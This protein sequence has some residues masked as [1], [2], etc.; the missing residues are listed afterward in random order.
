MIQNHIFFKSWSPSRFIVLLKVPI[1][2]FLSYPSSNLCSNWV[3]TERLT[4]WEISLDTELKKS[5][6]TSLV[7]VII[8]TIGGVYEQLLWSVCVFGAVLYTHPTKVWVGYWVVCSIFD[9]IYYRFHWMLV[10]SWWWFMAIVGR[11]DKNKSV[12][13]LNVFKMKR[14]VVQIYSNDEDPLNQICEIQ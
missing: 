13:W 7:G 3:I 5:I 6:R 2:I 4:F 11:K 9:L 8:T 1:S 14:M 12:C 10:F